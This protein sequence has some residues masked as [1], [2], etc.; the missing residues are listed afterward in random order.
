MLDL[1]LLHK[2]PPLWKLHR[3]FFA[4]RPRPSSANF[5]YTTRPAIC[6]AK[7]AKK[8]HKFQRPK[9]CTLTVRPTWTSMAGGHRR[10]VIRTGQLT[11]FCPPPGDTQCPPVGD[12]Y[13]YFFI[14]TFVSICA[15][16]TNTLA[17]LFSPVYW[18]EPML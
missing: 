1:C 11:L 13:R 18:T 6:Q 9:L 12:A 14:D 17:T 10:S 7:F 4:R 15:N 8:M 16:C 5:H 3:G 2:P